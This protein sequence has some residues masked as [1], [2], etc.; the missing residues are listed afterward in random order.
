MPVVKQV[1]ALQRIAAWVQA[2][3]S[4]FYEG[5]WYFAGRRVS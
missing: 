5:D 3:G 2:N 4:R 1:P